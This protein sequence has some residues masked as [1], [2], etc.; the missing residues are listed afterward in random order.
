MVG[1]SSESNGPGEGVAAVLVE[2]R[3]EK[4]ALN[5]KAAPTPLKVQ[6]TV[7]VEP[8]PDDRAIRPR[9]SRS[10]GKI[11][12]Q[13]PNLKGTR[14][15]VIPKRSTADLLVSRGAMWRKNGAGGAPRPSPGTLFAP[16]LA[17]PMPF[18]KTDVEGDGF[19]ENLKDQPPPQPLLFLPLMVGSMLIRALLDSGASDSFVSFDVVKTL[20]LT[21]HPLLQ[22]LTVRVANGE[23]LSVTHFVRLSGKLGQMPVKLLL[24]VI[25]TTIPVVLGYPFLSRVQP[26]VDWRRRVLRVERKG[27]VYEIPALPAADSFR[28]TFPVGAALRTLIRNCS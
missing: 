1:G 3:N 14:P 25:K 6:L 12:L 9:D 7:A 26:L 17:I 28:M 19:I 24:R 10:E 2:H 4:R 8:V 23:G 13:L 21:Q 22:P 27:R 20:W 11:T 18:G 15:L 5:G 16:L